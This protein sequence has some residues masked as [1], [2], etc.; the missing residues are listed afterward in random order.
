MVSKYF[1]DLSGVIIIMLIIYNIFNDCIPL[2]KNILGKKKK[3]N[4]ETP[5]IENI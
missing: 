3:K 4:L 1:L 5:I 2:Y